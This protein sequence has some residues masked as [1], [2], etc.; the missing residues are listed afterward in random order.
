MGVF[1]TQCG[2]TSVPAR[3]HQS[4][5]LSVKENELEISENFF[6]IF[7]VS[8]YAKYIEKI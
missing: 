7:L 6:C 1:T 5:A 8:I 3:A 4:V 2:V